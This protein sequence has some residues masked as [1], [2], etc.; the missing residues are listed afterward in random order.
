MVHMNAEPNFDSRTRVKPHEETPHN[1]ASDKL[2]ELRDAIQSLDAVIEI[3]ATKC[4]INPEEDEATVMASVHL[5]AEADAMAIHRYNKTI[6][7]LGFIESETKTEGDRIV[8]ALTADTFEESGQATKNP[9]QNDMSMDEN[10]G[11]EI[12]EGE[13]AEV[14]GE[15]AEIIGGGSD[16]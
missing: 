2:T 10:A 7:S 8:A 3:T 4:D 12:V 16:E 13:D 1:R 15:D 6:S 11:V 9:E 14:I 5:D